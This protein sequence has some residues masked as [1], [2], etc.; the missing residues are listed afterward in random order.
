[1]W[2]TG[3]RPSKRLAILASLAAAAVLPAV[4]LAQGRD[5]LDD[6]NWD[7]VLTLND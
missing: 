5:Q 2:G 4:A 3:A 6:E 1:M 7:I